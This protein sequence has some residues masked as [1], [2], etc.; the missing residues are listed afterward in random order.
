MGIIVALPF[1][2]SMSTFPTSAAAVEVASETCASCGTALAGTYCHACGEKRLHRH[3]YSFA[4]FLEHAVDAVTHLDLR[5][6]RDLGAQM[7]RP[8]W[9][10]AEW[11]RGRRVAHAPPVQ[12]FLVTNLL[13]YLLASA[14]H[15]SPFE[16]RLDYHQAT[17]IYGGWARG[18]VAD[19]LARSHTSWDL[20]AARFAQSAH[21]YSKSLVFLFVPLLAVPLWALFW[22]H[23]RY[24]VEWL[25]LSLYLFG[26]LL[27]VFAAAAVLVLVVRLVPPLARTVEQDGIL[28]PVMFGATT[29]YAAGFFRQ[30][31]PGTSGFGRWAKGVLY[32]AAFLL[33]LLFVYRWVLF[34]V[35]YWAA[36]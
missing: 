15:F 29:A 16:A 33:S 14:S 3:D 22:R 26:G 13:F 17:P 30:A 7:R 27:L 31:F 21:V 5:V 34:V 2:D 28:M 23:R 35:C 19:Y 6:V 11:L 18:L 9:V 8:G 4:H 20:F 10:A 12:L 32:T 1:P 25:T 24:F 36:T